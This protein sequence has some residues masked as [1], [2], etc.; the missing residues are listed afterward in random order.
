MYRNSVHIYTLHSSRLTIFLS[1]SVIYPPYSKYCKDFEIWPRISEYFGNCTRLCRTFAIFLGDSRIFLICIRCTK[2]INSYLRIC[3]IQW[4]TSGTCNFCP[5]Y[6]ITFF[7][8]PFDSFPYTEEPLDLSKPTEG[9]L[10][11]Y[12]GPNE[13]LNT[14]Q[15]VQKTDPT[16]SD[17]SGSSKGSMAISLSG[18]GTL[19]SLWSTLEL[20][21][22]SLSVHVNPGPLLSV[23][24]AGGP[25]LSFRGEYERLHLYKTQA[26]NSKYY[27]R[28]FGI[29]SI[30]H[31]ASR[32]TFICPIIFE[33]VTTFRIESETFP[34]LSW[35]SRNINICPTAFRN[36]LVIPRISRTLLEKCGFRIFTIWS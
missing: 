12:Q 2:K 3:D 16:A 33:S 27:T 5:T 35:C 26:R 10:T 9:P 13:Y 24:K 4:L 30:Y 28:S 7:P 22:M 19:G 14:P 36:F 34:V 8:N 23:Q 6:F 1:V 11:S 18:Q 31:S 25:C 20:L 15:R 29:F 32:I 17:M 21:T